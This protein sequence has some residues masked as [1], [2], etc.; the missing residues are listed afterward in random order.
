MDREE[1]IRQRAYR[2][3]EEEGR[4]EGRDRLHWDQ[5]AREVDGDPGEASTGTEETR[6]KSHS[7]DAG[8]ASPPSAVPGTQSAGRAARR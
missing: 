5:A 7:P 8:S 2:I 4:P 6:R 3:W 1:M